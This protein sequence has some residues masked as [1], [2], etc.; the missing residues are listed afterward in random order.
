MPSQT[1]AIAEALVTSVREAVSKWDEHGR[2]T[3][4]FPDSGSDFDVR[5][6]GVRLIIEVGPALDKVG[7]LRTFAKMTGAPVQIR[8]RA[9]YLNEFVERYFADQTEATTVLQSILEAHKPSG[10]QAPRTVTGA[11][12]L[13]DPDR[14]SIGADD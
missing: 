5:G 14:P 6:Q 13:D 9:W 12:E 2:W 10:R 3:I 11:P 1:R 8:L 4:V 7:I